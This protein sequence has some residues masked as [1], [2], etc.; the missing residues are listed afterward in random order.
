MT[1]LAPVS[2]REGINING[3]HK[4]EQAFRVYSK[5]ITSRFPHKATELLKYNHTIHN[6]SV[7][8]QWENVYS[9]DKEFR[10]HISRHPTRSWG[11]ILQQVWT[12]LLKDRVRNDNSVFH[13]DSYPGKQGN[14]RGKI[15][16]RFNK[17]RCTYRLSCHYEHCCLVPKCGKF[18]HG[19]HICRLRHTLTE[20]KDR[21][22][23]EPTN[24]AHGNSNANNNNNLQEHKK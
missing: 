3:Y 19:A 14:K 18:G 11:V 9:Y 22:H 13:K 16:K 4:W 12:M 5:M 6:A 2:D 20:S 17:G 1:Y 10:Y 7:V 23:K 8:Y 15:C 21:T 24:N